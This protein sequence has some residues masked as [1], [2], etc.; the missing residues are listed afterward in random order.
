MKRFSPL[1]WLL[2][3]LP[4]LSF[5]EG[6]AWPFPAGAAFFEDTIQRVAGPLLNPVLGGAEFGN[7]Y[8]VMME[9][10]LGVVSL[11]GIVMIVRA[12]LMLAASQEEGQLEKARKVIINVSV[13]LILLNLAPHIA[14]ALLGYNRGGVDIIKQELIGLLNFFETVAA[15]AAIVFIIVSGVRAVTTYGGEDGPAHLKRALIGVGAGI[16]LIATKG[17]IVR[18]VVTE[19]TPNAILGII[20]TFVEAVLGLGAL[21]ATIVLIWAG[22]LMIVNLGKDEQYTRAKTLVVRVGIGLIVILS[23][24]AIVQFV[25]S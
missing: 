6:L 13:A 3:L 24:M 9:S 4:A 25:I 7:I 1:H 11:V 20:K 21:V 2:L 15:V 5:V 17:L 18:A 8:K 22:L 14:E 12:G 16:L 10:F 19:R 23:S